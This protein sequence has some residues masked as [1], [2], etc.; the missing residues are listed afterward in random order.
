M[1]LKTKTSKSMKKSF[2][3]VEAP[4]TAVNIYLYGREIDEF[5]G[6]TV[7]IDLTK[8]LRG[9]NFVLT[10]RIRKE[11]EKLIGEPYNLI[12]VSS[13]TRK[14]VRKGVN[15]VED[16]IRAACKDKAV[17]IKPL[18]ITKSKVSKTT[19][20]ILRDNCRKYIES[21][22]SIRTAEELFKDIIANKIQKELAVKL[23]K[24]YPLILSDI[25]WFEVEENKKVNNKNVDESGEEASEEIVKEE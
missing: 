3:K 22:V 12:L 24:I 8:N 2:Y 23:K 25:R 20:R 17:V 5:D 11:G 15:Y 19:R 9:K 7:K 14:S 6:R 10:L 16:S 18:L 1:A 4:I 21:Y 13:Y